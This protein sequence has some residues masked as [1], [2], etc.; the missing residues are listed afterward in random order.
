[1]APSKKSANKKVDSPP[2]K[3]AKKQQADEPTE[4]VID[5][6][7]EE[8]ERLTREREEI[9]SKLNTVC[10]K[11]LENVNPDNYSD[12]ID[13]NKQQQ[14]SDIPTEHLLTMID[15]ICH[16]RT[17]FLNLFQEHDDNEKVP[18]QRKITQ[19]AIEDPHL[20]R[21][22][23]TSDQRLTFVVRERDLW[24]ENAQLLQIMYATIGS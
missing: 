9:R 23:L 1:M 3:K 12:E 16:Y 10:S 7:K 6:H 24:K 2:T 8:I 20:F 19:L 4:D 21:K 15:E 22:R 13:F 14:P 11:I 17:A 5:P 18:V